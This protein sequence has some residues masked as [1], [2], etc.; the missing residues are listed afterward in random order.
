MS[1]LVGVVKLGFLYFLS[2]FLPPVTHTALAIPIM[3][4]HQEGMDRCIPIPFIL[5]L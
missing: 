2:F 4:P 1:V 5:W 3:Q